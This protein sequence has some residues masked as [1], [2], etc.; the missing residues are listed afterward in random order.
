MKEERRNQG[1]RQR[2]GRHLMLSFYSRISLIRGSLSFAPATLGLLSQMNG[3]NQTRVLGCFL[4]FPLCLHP[5]VTR[6]PGIQAPDFPGHHF[7]YAHFVKIVLRVI[8]T[9]F[10]SKYLPRKSNHDLVGEVSMRAFLR[11][12]FFKL[13]FLSFF[14]TSSLRFRFSVY[15]YYTR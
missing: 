8:S 2:K 4:P 13:L 5:K 1:G 6:R 12:R 10:T 7:N 15:R 9:F 11:L 3:L 14:I